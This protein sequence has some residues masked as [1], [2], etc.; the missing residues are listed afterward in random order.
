[1]YATSFPAKI[2]QVK[3]NIWCLHD[4]TLGEQDDSYAIVTTLQK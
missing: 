1:M 2:N 3:I 4:L